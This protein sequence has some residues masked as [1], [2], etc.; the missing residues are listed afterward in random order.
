MDVTV[1]NT[2]IRFPDMYVGILL[3]IAH[4]YAANS[5]DSTAVRLSVKIEYA[6]RHLSRV[7]RGRIVFD[8]INS[9]R[10]IM[11]DSTACINVEDRQLPS[12]M[13]AAVARSPERT[14]S[15][16]L[17][18]Q[19]ITGTLE[20]ASWSLYCCAAWAKYPHLAEAPCCWD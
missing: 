13:R 16:A 1:D 2:N 14:T 11:N 18:L 15:V 7:L 9:G 10:L 4:P 17:P 5:P 8:A 3:V 12:T 20:G 19:T 6:L